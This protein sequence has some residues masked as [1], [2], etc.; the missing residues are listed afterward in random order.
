MKKIIC[1]AL[2]LFMLFGFSSCVIRMA[3]ETEIDETPSSEAETETV[4]TETSQ[5]TTKPA[6]LNPDGLTITIADVARYILAD[7]GEGYGV[8]FFASDVNADENKKIGVLNYLCIGNDDFHLEKKIGNF[9]SYF[10]RIYVVEFDMSSDLYKGL[11]TGTNF[12]F[13]EGASKTKLNVTA[14]NK[15]YVIS[16]SA[17]LGTDGGYNSEDCEET[18]PFSIGK[19]QEAYEAFINITSDGSM[20]KTISDVSD[21]VYT[22]AELK[23]DRVHTPSEESAIE[24]K[25]AGIV[26]CRYLSE[27]AT[28]VK[29]EGYDSYQIAI[30]IA[31]YDMNSE[32]YKNLKVGDEIE[33]WQSMYP[34]HLKVTAINKQ[35]ILCCCENLAKGTA[36]NENNQVSDAPFRIER[37]QKAYEVFT[38]LM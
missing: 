10:V 30:F 34:T 13:F 12:M 26:D 9:D 19:A 21:K 28:N 33:V 20:G 17:G 22:A 3:P 32:K 23:L 38:K 36:F 14:I 29:I 37:L 16:I 5:E 25:K 1:A 27:I 31:E 18:V 2:T 6:P 35:Y 4:T 7:M 11:A 8:H 15:Q 24:N